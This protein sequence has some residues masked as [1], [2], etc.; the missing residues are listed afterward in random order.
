M[1]DTTTRAVIPAR[2]QSQRFPSKVLALWRDK[3]VLEWVWRATIACEGFANVV[4]ATGDDAIRDAAEAFGASVHL[5]RAPYANGTERAAGA[6]HGTPGDVVVVQADQPGLQTQHLNALLTALQT[7][8]ADMLTPCV[9]LDSADID[10]RD[11]VKCW[12]EPT[13]DQ[14]HFSRQSNTCGVDL[15]RHVG[16]YAYREQALRQYAAF[17]I[18]EAEET[19]RLEQLRSLAAGHQVR[20]VA[21]PDAAPCVDRPEDLTRRRKWF[22]RSTP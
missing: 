8:D 22:S 4:I 5:D 14:A 10:N 1:R 16:I 9:P 12:S 2:L 13:T 6:S 7:V 3:T 17:G 18:C 15:W 19:H 20:L 21:L 11:V